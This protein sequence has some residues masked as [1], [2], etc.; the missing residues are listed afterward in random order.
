MDLGLN[1]SHNFLLSGKNVEVVREL[2][3]VDNSL[4]EEEINIWIHQL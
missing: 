1:A 2:L 3:V 4:E